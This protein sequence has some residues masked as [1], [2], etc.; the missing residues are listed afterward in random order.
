[1]WSTNNLMAFLSGMMSAYYNN[2]PDVVN[3]KCSMSNCPLQHNTVK[4]CALTKDE[5][6]Y[7]TPKYN[8]QD[9]AEFLRFIADKLSQ[10]I[11]DEKN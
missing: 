8:N 5:C 10:E 1:M 4:T 11:S 2:K 9:I 3:R 7:Y 6:Q